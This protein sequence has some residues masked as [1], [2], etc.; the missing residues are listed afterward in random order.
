[1]VIKFINKILNQRN[2]LS[3]EL[4]L[5]EDG[6]E[7]QVIEVEKL[8]NTLSINSSKTFNDIDSL[9]QSIPKNLPVLL[10]ITGNGII[11]KKVD[12]STNYRNKL[13][14]NATAEDFYWYELHQEEHIYASVIRKSILDGEMLE[15]QKNQIYIVDISIGPLIVTSIKPLLP[16]INYI[17]TQ[18]FRV[19]FI[20]E[21]IA[22]INN[23]INID[24][25][26]V[27][28]IDS[29]RIDFIN[30]VPFANLVNYI[31]PNS[32]ISAENDFLKIN[33]EEFKYKKSFNTLGIL[34]L[35]TFLL[36]L[37]ASYLLLGYYQ[38]EYIA[39][40]VKI[41]EES[42]VY[43]KL[44]LLETD[45]DNKEAMLKESGL[46]NS[47]FLSFYISKITSQ[48]PAEISLNELSIFSPV[49]KIKANQRII[50]DNDKISIEGETT[51]N[52]D[53]ADWIKIIKTYHWVENLEIID[54]R[55][56][57]R[58]SVFLIKIKLKKNV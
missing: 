5:K 29:E 39:L 9:I 33:R 32:K 14:F 18:N 47:T 2:F 17:H 51:S 37:L 26:V 38:G 44:K 15:L 55:K 12:N 43:D 35:P 11:T 57:G 25:E 46:N 4:R 50:F 13:L 23:F 10:S 16:K 30:I 22:G 1:M 31:Y 24:D 56:E 3:I 21:N 48:M 28:E 49:E 40:Q 36:L 42:I 6:K 45:R 58:A 53:F 27:Y 41:E 19:D 52:D 54:F 8:E 7:Y 20:G 34:A